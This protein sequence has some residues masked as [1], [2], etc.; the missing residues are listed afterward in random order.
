MKNGVYFGTVL[1]PHKL[2]STYLWTHESLFS[3]DA[4]SSGSS[5]VS[6]ENTEKK[7]DETYA[8]NT[9]TYTHA[10]ETI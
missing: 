3:R 10:F 7:A 8:Q 6:L 9:Q 1:P 5:N 4:W 2:S